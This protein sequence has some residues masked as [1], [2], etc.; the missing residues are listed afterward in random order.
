M[1]EVTSFL[2]ADDEMQMKLDPVMEVTRSSDTGDTADDSE[3]KRQLRL[4]NL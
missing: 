4:K 2:T 3:T 1:N